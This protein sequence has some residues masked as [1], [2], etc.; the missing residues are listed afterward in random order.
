MESSSSNDGSMNPGLNWHIN[1]SAAIEKVIWIA[2]NRTLSLRIE[3]LNSINLILFLQS[4]RAVS[5]KVKSVL[6]E[7]GRF[8]E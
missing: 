6:G 1:V 2:V 8:Y 5:L 4:R 3:I 7:K